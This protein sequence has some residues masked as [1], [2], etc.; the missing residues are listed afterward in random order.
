MLGINRKDVIRFSMLLG[1]LLLSAIALHYNELSQV[2]GDPVFLALS[3]LLV[4]AY[5]SCTGQLN[6]FHAL[7]SASLSTEPLYKAHMVKL[8]RIN[9]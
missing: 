6:T 8:K 2:A 4:L 7:F 1:T 5:Y 3:P 9:K